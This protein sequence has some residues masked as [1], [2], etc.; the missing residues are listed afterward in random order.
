MKKFLGVWVCCVVAMAL[1]TLCGGC[2]SVEDQE[3][4]NTLVREEKA[5][6][7]ERVRAVEALLAEKKDLRDNLKAKVR[8]IRE[9]IDDGTLTAA[10]GK[11]FIAELRADIA[12]T[13][14]DVNDE[15]GAIKERFVESQDRIRNDV[16]DIESRGNSK[17]DIVFAGLV[18]LL[19]GGGTLGAARLWRGSVNNRAGD[20]GA[21]S[22]TG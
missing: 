13:V 3:K 14:S 10:T 22:P 1:M 12:D 8:E 11:A 17:I 2:V 4:I 21:R 20:I 16:K 7:E 6:W 9:G 19:T 15:I 18:S 5:L